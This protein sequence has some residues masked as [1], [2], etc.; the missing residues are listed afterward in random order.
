MTIAEIVKSPG[1]RLAFV[2]WLV[3][4]HSFLVGIGLIIRPTTLMQL[5]AFNPCTERFFPVQGG[6]FHIVMVAA[7]VM[8]AVD[9]DRFRCLVVYSI[10]VKGIATVFLFTYFLAVDSIW[11]VLVS[12]LCDGAMGVVIY[13][14]LRS[15]SRMQVNPNCSPG[16]A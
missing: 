2:L 10:I 6:V 11:L 4:I 12:G 1:L 3:A 13:W 8:A 14:C 7:Y 15:Y 5:F 16:A 9:V